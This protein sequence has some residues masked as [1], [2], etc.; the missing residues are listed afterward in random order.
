MLFSDA[1]LAKSYPPLGERMCQLYKYSSQD[2]KGA[3]DG[4][5]PCRYNGG[6]HEECFAATAGYKYCI[7]T[8]GH[9]ECL[10]APK[11]YGHCIFYKK[12]HA[13]C[14]RPR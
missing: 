1:A 3:K 13:K 11:S 4:Y 14:M 5:G 2:C 9:N 10:K 8:H 6:G 12:N 7:T